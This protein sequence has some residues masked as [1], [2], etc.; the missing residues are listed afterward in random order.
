MWLGLAAWKL[1]DYPTARREGEAGLALKRRAGIDAELSQSFNA[2]GLL[3]WNQGRLRDALL[4]Y[5]SADASARRHGDAK[6]IARAAGNAGLVQYELGH[7]DEA[8][9]RIHRDAGYG[10]RDRR[11]ALPGQRARQSRHAPRSAS[12]TPPPRSRCW[13]GPGGTTP[14]STTPP[15]RPTPWVS[16]PPRG[17]I[18]ATSSSPSP[19]PTRGSPS[20]GGSGVP[21]EVAATHRGAGRSARPGGESPPCPGAPA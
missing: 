13:P 6:G 2:L 15:A 10:G 4:L 8:R 11:G 14:Q 18:W 16:S 20:P 9:R 12:A 7:Y 3:A 5:D 17:A 19:P 21:Q 1:G